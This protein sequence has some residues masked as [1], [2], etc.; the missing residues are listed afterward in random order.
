MTF[1]EELPLNNENKDLNT[2][3]FT[4]HYVNKTN[5]E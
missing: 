3:N 1:A 2:G 5:D 4:V